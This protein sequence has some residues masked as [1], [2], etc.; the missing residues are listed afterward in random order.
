MFG[1]KSVTNFT[2]RRIGKKKYDNLNITSLNRD[3]VRY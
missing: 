1:R 2:T 3:E